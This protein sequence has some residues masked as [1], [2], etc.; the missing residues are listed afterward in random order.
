MG[1]VHAQQHEQCRRSSESK[2]PTQGFG[3]GSGQ[4]QVPKTHFSMRDV[5]ASREAFV[6]AVV[7]AKRDK[8]ASGT[9]LRW[10]G[11]RGYSQ[12]FRQYLAAGELPGP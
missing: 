9:T 4:Q 5:K 7:K 11:A 10:L 12:G 1:K 8:N 6:V 2:E 3:S